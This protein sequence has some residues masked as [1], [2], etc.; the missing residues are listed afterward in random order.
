M[1]ES[2][3][4][5]TKVNVVKIEIYDIIERQSSLNVESQKLEQLKQNKLKELGTFRQKIEGDKSD[6]GT[7]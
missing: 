4:L 7:H 3:D 1:S 6:V 5:T 2:T